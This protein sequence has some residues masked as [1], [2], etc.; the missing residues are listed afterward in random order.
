LRDTGGKR[1]RLNWRARET[2]RRLATGRRQLRR[3]M[4]M[5]GGRVLAIR[6]RDCV[7]LHFCAQTNWHSARVSPLLHF[8]KPLLSSVAHLL[9]TLLE[10]RAARTHS[11][12]S[13]AGQSSI[14]RSS[15]ALRSST[16]A[17]LWPHAQTDKRTRRRGGSEKA[18]R[19]QRRHLSCGHTRALFVI[20]GCW[21][22]AGEAARDD[23]DLVAIR[24]QS[25]EFKRRLSS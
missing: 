12:V 3:V 17:S 23:D 2:G 11:E 10:L 6:E 24:S 20:Y 21:C 15:F 16:A 14:R 5:M 13:P 4:M 22:C 19:R 1:A 9:A 8:S 25:L 18:A 7:R